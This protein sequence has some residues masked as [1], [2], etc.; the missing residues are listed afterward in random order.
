V[1]GFQ[2]AGVHSVF[3]NGCDEFGN[4]VA[5]GVYFYKIQTGSFEQTRKMILLL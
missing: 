4:T 5:S 1:N 2:Q 3:W